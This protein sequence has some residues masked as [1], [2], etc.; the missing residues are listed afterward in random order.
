MNSYFERVIACAAEVLKVDPHSLDKD[1]SFNITKD[2]DS[3]SHLNIL[4]CLEKIYFIEFT[5]DD[6]VFLTSVADIAEKL[7]ELLD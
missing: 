6:F 5:E 7:E 3:I 2:W 4:I 1:S